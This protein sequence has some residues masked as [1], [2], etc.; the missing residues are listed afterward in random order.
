MFVM[1]SAYSVICD[2]DSEA[3]ERVEHQVYDSVWAVRSTSKAQGT[4]MN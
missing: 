4:V 3:E 1:F 2:I